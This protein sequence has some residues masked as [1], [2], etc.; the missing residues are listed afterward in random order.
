MLTVTVGNANVGVAEMVGVNVIVGGTVTVEVKVASGVKV[1]VGVSVAVGGRGVGVA[2][3]AGA[4]QA[5]IAR[6]RII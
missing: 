5:N 2:P 6:T 1:K 3:M 4:P